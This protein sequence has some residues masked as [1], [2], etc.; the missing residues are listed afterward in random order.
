MDTLFPNTIKLLEKKINKTKKQISKCTEYESIVKLNKKY[1][2]YIT[3]Y[4]LLIK[5][6]ETKVDPSKYNDILDV[7]PY[8]AE[9]YYIMKGIIEE[10]EN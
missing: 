2:E 6:N 4:N 3:E 5:M 8:I 9:L 10:D 1:T 7:Y